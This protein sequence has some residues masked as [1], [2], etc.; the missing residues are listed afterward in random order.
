MASGGSAGTREAARA[1]IGFAVAWV[2][3]TLLTS[4]GLYGIADNVTNVEL[5][6]H[7]AEEILVNGQVPY[8]DFGIEYPPLGIAAM[9]VPSFIAGLHATHDQYRPA[10]QLVMLACGLVTAFAGVKAVAGFGGTQRDMRAAAILLAATPLLLGPTILARFDLAPVAFVALGLWA[11]AIERQLVG[12]SFL[13][14]GVIAKLF[15]ILLAPA[16][17]AWL[18]RRDGLAAAIQWASMFVLVLLLGFGPF[19]LLDWH[20]TTNLLF[21]RTLERPLQVEAFGAVLLFLANELAG[22]PISLVHTYDSWNLEGELPDLLAV[23][24]T[25][26][27]LPILAGVYLLVAR[28]SAGD[29][30]AE[31]HRVLLAMAAALAVY[32]ALGKAFSPQYVLWL[33]PSVAATAATGRRA[34]LVLLALV[35]LVTS[36]YYPGMYWEF[37]HERWLGPALVVLARNV[38]VCGL[39]AL[40]VVALVRTRGTPT[41]APGPAPGTAPGPAPS[42]AGAAAG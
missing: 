36:V 26:L 41:P 10:F 32:V 3:V 15:P 39:G 40:L 1:A 35:I 38:L 23:A 33:V 30:R 19:L 37:F 25:A 4:T 22:L 20:E 16:I 8:D 6:R 27:T 24:Q 17:L 5:Y 42:P 28:R 12:A 34:P 13:A 18:W 2:A 14:L 21:A 7:W 29:E 9:L 31:L 11:L